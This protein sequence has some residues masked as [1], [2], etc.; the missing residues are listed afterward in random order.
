MLETIFL[1]FPELETERLLLRRLTA[2]DA[3]ALFF[4][5]SSS[6]VMQHIDRP[7]ASTI[8]EVEAFIQSIENNLETGNGILWA[9]ALKNDPA[10]LIGTICYW[11]ISRENYRAETGYMLHPDH[12][13]KGIMKEALL[14]V[15]E[16]GFDTMKLHSIEA[17]LNAKN[18]ASAAV[19]ESTGFVREAYF[20]EDCF[21]D[22]KFLDTAVYSK[23]R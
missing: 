3:A 17:R 6:T 19:L 2:D 10:I 8:T 12:W 11:Q 16:Y 23:L 20:K 7:P 4:L 21:Y 14:K 5:R 1:P 13:R 18:T 15:I 9:I 22:G